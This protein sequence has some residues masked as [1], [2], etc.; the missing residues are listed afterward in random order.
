MVHS[1]HVSLSSVDMIQDLLVMIPC[2]TELRSFSI[3]LTI[4]T[5]DLLT[6]GAVASACND[7]LDPLGPSRLN[8][9][10]HTSISTTSLGSLASHCSQPSRHHYSHA[11]SLSLDPYNR[12]TTPTAGLQQEDDETIM[13]SSTSQ[14]GILLSMLANSCPKLENVWFS[15]FHPIAV[16]G[17]PTDLRPMP[18]KFD[19]KSY[20][21]D[22]SGVESPVVRPP[23]FLSMGSLHSSIASASSSS[24]G[25]SSQL[26]PVPPVPGINFA[27][28]NTSTLPHSPATNQQVVQS[29]IQSVHFV[30]CTVP[31]QYLKTMIQHA[32][33]NLTELHLTQCWKGNPLQG[34]ILDSI[35]KICPGLRKLTLHAT[36]SHRGLISSADV[37]RMLQ[38]LESE[39][40]HVVDTGSTSGS[41]QG[42]GEGI[43]GNTGLPGGE[44]GM[45]SLAD[46][47]LGSF[48]KTSYTAAS[49][50]SAGATIGSSSI[51]N[52]N[53]S[54]SSALVTIPSSASST[55][56]PT[57]NSNIGYHRQR[58]QDMNLFDQ[59]QQHEVQ[60]QEMSPMALPSPSA[61]ESI[62]IWFT[63]S[64][65]D[66]AIVAELANQERHPRLRNV[67][68]GSE[69]MFDV[70]EDL[71]RELR[72]QRPELDAFWV[73]YGDTG[74]DRDD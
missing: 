73:H 1:L 60:E 35:A 15:G 65:L 42:R 43:G 31:P 61:L 74:E 67:E 56:D 25:P 4:P 49:V 36:E 10:L 55:S 11:H 17:G 18:P 62:S 37:L 14:S 8:S 9:T 40:Q 72:E 34:H 13:A 29:K 39:P 33:P 28:M 38:G 44:R 52:S 16:L 41:S 59:Q 45:A 2:C 30:N 53:S 5:E 7:L 32:L 54:S 70:G 12:T 71:I 58:R 50:S 24:I 26:S 47:P 20:Y 19:I 51:S 63:H 57:T 27:A 46:F 68:F 6:R 69:D 21:D 64:I 23:S 66:R 22:Q 3:Q 48:R